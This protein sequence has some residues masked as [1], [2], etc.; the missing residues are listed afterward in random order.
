M[1][2][3]EKKEKLKRYLIDT[4]KPGQDL[5]LQKELARR[6]GIHTGDISILTREL[7]ADGLLEKVHSKLF[8]MRPGYVDQAL[9]M[10][11]K[12]IANNAFSTARRSW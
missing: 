2:H 5:P 6:A 9:M 3:S 4:L 10:H 8:R 11:L 1:S 12:K 7:A